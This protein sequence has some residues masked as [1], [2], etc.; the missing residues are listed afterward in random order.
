MSQSVPPSALRT[1][2]SGGFTWNVLPAFLWTL[3]IFIGASGGPPHPFVDMPFGFDKF[4][5]AGAFLGLQFLSYRA[6]RYGLPDFG[7]VALRWLGAA[8]SVFAGIALEV[9][10]AGLPDRSAEIQDVIA[11]AVGAVIGALVLK[12]WS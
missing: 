5:H 3:G 7:R 1:P 4:E 9:Y 10:Q 6:L 2:P 8:A 11:D 12:F